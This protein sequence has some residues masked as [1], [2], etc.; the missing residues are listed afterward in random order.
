LVH[1][2]DLESH[3][4]HVAN[5]RLERFAGHADMEPVFVCGAH[6]ANLTQQ[7]ERLR[8]AERTGQRDTT[9]LS[10]PDRCTDC[11]QPKSGRV[12]RSE[13]LDGQTSTEA[14]NITGLVYDPKNPNFLVAGTVVPNAGQAMPPYVWVRI[15]GAS[16]RRWDYAVPVS[17][18]GVFSA[19][20]T[21]P[22]SALSGGPATVFVGPYLTTAQ[23]ATNGVLQAGS[24]PPQYSNATNSNSIRFDI[25]QSAQI[26]NIAFTYSRPSLSTLQRGLLASNWVNYVNPSTTALADSIMQGITSPLSKAQAIYNWIMNNLHYNGAEVENSDYAWSTTGEVLA[27]KSGICVDYA[28]VYAALSRAVGIPTEEIGGIAI[29]S[30][31]NGPHQWDRSWINGTWI[32]ADPTFSQLYE[33]NNGFIGPST[34][35]ENSPQYFNFGTNPTLMAHHQTQ[36]YLMR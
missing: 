12:K 11:Q 26:D 25:A 18:T 1:H 19:V 4:I 2:A 16:G 7:H 22:F 24:N 35:Y 29:A 14:I 31:V 15:I 13:Q 34:P 23:T 6:Q 32:Y 17:S 10:I 33:T 21:N 20:L 36:E 9:Y 30:G 28:D 5:G 3:Q 8:V 27:I